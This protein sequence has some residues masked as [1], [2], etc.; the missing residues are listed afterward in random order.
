MCG[1]VSLRK[2]TARILFLLANIQIG[3]E[4]FFFFFAEKIKDIY[5]WRV[6]CIWENFFYTY[7]EKPEQ[8]KKMYEKSLRS[9]IHFI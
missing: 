2:R 7:M 1:F 8:P 9:F 4:L 6:F 3:G 5:G